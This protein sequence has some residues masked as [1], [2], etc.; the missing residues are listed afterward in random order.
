MKILIAEDDADSRIYL[1]RILKGNHFTVE[2]A[3]NGLSA[4][5]KAQ[6]SPPDLIISDILM[7]ELD[8]FALCLQWKK[9]AIL[10]N[11]PFIFYTAT[12]TGLEDEQLALNLG[13]ERFVTKPQPPEVLLQIIRDVLLET[14]N[15]MSNSIEMPLR[16]TGIIEQYNAALFRKLEKKVWEL[17]QEADKRKKVEAELINDIVERKHTEELLRD[18]EARYRAVI[19]QAF[20]GIV[21]CEPDTGLILEGNARF[22]EQFGYKLQAGSPLY[23]SGLIADDSENV[24]QL[25]KALAEDGYLP[26]RRSTFK[27]WH[28]LRIPVIRIGTLIQYQGRRLL[29]LT[30]RDISDEIQREQEIL[31][32]AEM[33]R[34]VQ[35]A[36]LSPLKPNIHV[37]VQTLYHPR[38]YVGGDLYFLDWRNEGKLLRGFLL[39]AMG[40]G[41]SRA[42][43]AAAQHV[44]LR[45]LNETD[46]PLAEQVKLLNRRI[47][48]HF[49]EGQTAKGIAFEIDLELR[50]LRWVDAGLPKFWLHSQTGSVQ[51]GNPGIPLG[52]TTNEPFETHMVSLSIGDALY[53]CTD[54]LSSMLENRVTMPLNQY[55]DMV[56]LLQTLAISK[57]CQDDAT[58][59]CI[60]IHSFPDSS[61]RKEGWP[62]L[63]RFNS[64]SDFT[65]LKG[66]VAKILTEVTGL[67]HSFHEVAVNEALANAMECRD[68]VPRQHKASIRFNKVGNRLIIRVKSSRMGF[69]G[70][71]I[72]RR[73]RSHPED[74]FAYGEDAAMGRGIPMMLCMSHKMTYNSEGTEV[75][76]AWKM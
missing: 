7:P 73:L 3:E 25:M 30:F 48:E 34:R 28:G 21:I 55:H 67:P 75:L 44:M 76:L 15:K 52:V 2:S 53:Y 46:L 24:Q 39:E 10:K 68:G 49:T 6:H 64:Y 4:W 57:E 35:K 65:R 69:A 54:G 31:H 36:L 45:E 41:L 12:Y 27:D 9:D 50:E 63:L 32:D 14:G 26:P 1:E 60:S 58:A 23:L 70:N 17:E 47:T 71:S 20:E 38:L 16:E 18:S 66:E 13:A 22:E 74:M 62:K 40:Q 56:D 11:I 51:M 29:T 61:V 59:V 37:E 19:A 42:L 5:N 8:G 72:L 43:Y 33:A